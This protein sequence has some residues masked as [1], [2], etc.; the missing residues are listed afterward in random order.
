LAE[1]EVLGINPGRKPHSEPKNVFTPSYVFRDTSLSIFE[2]WVEYLKDKRN[3]SFKQIALIT[4]R[5]ERNIWTVY[6][7]AKKKRDK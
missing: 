5:D 1:K 3:L 7:R 2:A 6:Q 4:N